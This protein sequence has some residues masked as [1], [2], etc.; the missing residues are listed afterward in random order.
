M[1][2]QYTLFSYHFID[3]YSQVQQ[4]HHRFPF[5]QNQNS[6]IMSLYLG[7][8]AYEICYICFLLNLQSK[9]LRLTYEFKKLENCPYLRPKRDK[10]QK[11]HATTRLNEKTGHL[12]SI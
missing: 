11:I 2:D 9:H 4:I 10:I 1:S 3:E 7:Q 12:I 5:L 8:N 6:K